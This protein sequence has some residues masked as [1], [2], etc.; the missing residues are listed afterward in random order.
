[1]IFPESMAS[2]R[3]IGRVDEDSKQTEHEN[4]DVSLSDNNAESDEDAT[5]ESEN[6]FMNQVWDE[7][8]EFVDQVLTNHNICRDGLATS[9]NYCLILIVFILFLFYCR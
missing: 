3:K 8:V 9:T 4:N 6:E 2:S 1:M 5:D 7:P